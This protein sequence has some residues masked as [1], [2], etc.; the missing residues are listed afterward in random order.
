MLKNE[1]LV[2]FSALPDKIIREILDSSLTFEKN[3]ET[4]N[5]DLMKNTGR[6]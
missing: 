2:K 5:L 1:S 4:L 3:P 6:L